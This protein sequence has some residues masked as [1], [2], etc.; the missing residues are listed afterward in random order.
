MRSAWD[1]TEQEGVNKAPSC[2]RI[3]SVAQDDDSGAVTPSCDEPRHDGRIAPKSVEFLAETIPT[4]APV[5]VFED[6]IAATNI[7]EVPNQQQPVILGA[8]RLQ[9]RWK[10]AEPGT[11][12]LAYWES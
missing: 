6:S 1:A 12:K 4:P 3:Y 7:T 2:P 9:F 10:R 8:K 11:S 5:T